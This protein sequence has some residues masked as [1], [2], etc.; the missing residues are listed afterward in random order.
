M[1]KVKQNALSKRTGRNSLDGVSSSGFHI[2][3]VITVS[4]ASTTIDPTQSYPVSAT[5]D[6]NAGVIT[7]IFIISN[8][9]VITPTG[10]A[11]SQ[12]G[13]TATATFSPTDMANLVQPAT[14]VVTGIDSTGS[15]E[16]ITPLSVVQPA[17]MPP[18]GITTIATTGTGSTAVTTIVGKVPSGYTNLSA[19]PPGSLDQSSLPVFT[20]KV[21]GLSLPATISY[22]AFNPKGVSVM[23]V[24]PL[25]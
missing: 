19:I 17:V 25:A 3:V 7:G 10:V 1:S 4:V 9:N 18:V 8:G 2:D 6:T 22:T 11:L 13:T 21:K 15:A 20:H 24:V 14:L 12:T 23:F 16:A 5:V